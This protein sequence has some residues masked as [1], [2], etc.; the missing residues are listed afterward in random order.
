[1]RKLSE[2]IVLIKG[3]GEVAS[4]IAHVALPSQRWFLIGQRLSKG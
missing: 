1:M 4:G 3:G 2:L